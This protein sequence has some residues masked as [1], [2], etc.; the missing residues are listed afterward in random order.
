MTKLL[1]HFK[2]SQSLA[3]WYLLGSLLAQLKKWH[4]GER[5]NEQFDHEELHQ[6]YLE[7]IIPSLAKF[8]QEMAATGNSDSQLLQLHAEPLC[9]TLKDQDA[10]EAVLHFTSGYTLGE[11]PVD[12]R[13]TVIEIKCQLDESQRNM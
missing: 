7:A 3:I 1:K 11:L 2:D 13:L 12:F 4:E 9:I 6:L 10:I 8:Q 5:P